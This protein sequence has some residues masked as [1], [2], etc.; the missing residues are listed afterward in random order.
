MNNKEILKLYYNMVENEKIVK[1]KRE[2]LDLLDKYTQNEDVLIG[3]VE[4]KE[5]VV[6]ILSKLQEIESEMHSIYS[7]QVFIKAFKLG[8]NLG[9]E[10][11]VKE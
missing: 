10:I 11:F 4:N 6:E 8:V 7:E 5:K 9:V 3:M 1:Q 2:Y